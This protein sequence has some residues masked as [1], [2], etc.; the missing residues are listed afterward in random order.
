MRVLRILRNY[1]CY[2]GIEKNEYNA[3]KKDAYVSNFRIWRILHC[4]MAVVFAF[5]LI[6]SVFNDLLLQNMVF[7][8]AAF[9]YS[10][11]ITC[12]FFFMKEDSIIA[13]LLIYLSISF[14]FLF[15][16]FITR[17]NSDFPATTFVVMLIIS[18]MFMIDKPYFMAIE[19]LAASVVFLVWMYN[20]KP[21]AVWQ[22]DFVNIA[23]FS[24]VGFVIHTISNSIRIKEFVLTREINLQKDMDELTGL[25]NKG[26]LTRDINKFMADPSNNKGIFFILDID[27]FK[28]INDTYG[29]DVGDSVIHQLGNFLNGYFTKGETVGR[30]GGDEFIF[31]VK[32]VN[33]DDTAV[34]TARDIVTGVPEH[35][36]L[37]DKE[38]KVNV[39]IGIAIYNG[40]EKNYSE[41]FKKADMALYCAKSERAEGY[42]IY[43]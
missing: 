17:N 19:L 24:T 27:R 6:D 23:V 25:K 18:P 28:M 20:V 12:V 10:I 43:K 21:Y 39:S 31:F 22:M 16:A 7:Y 9:I 4:L 35:I 13:Q 2:C 14:L 36:A 11:V 5:L 34:K 8:F 41:I 29:H 37:P 33:D 26:A 40:I 15:A 32:N 1:L 42:K 30:F 38:R 3:I